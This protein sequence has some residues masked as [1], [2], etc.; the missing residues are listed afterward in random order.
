MA[1]SDQIE[2][3]EDEDPHQVDEVP[4]EPRELYSG[5]G[6]LSRA[7]AESQS[8]KHDDPD[9]HVSSVKSGDEEEKVAERGHVPG[10]ASEGHTFANEAPPFVRLHGKERDTAS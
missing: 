6:G 9:E 5:G 10:V 7:H 2:Q 4:V 1:T 8:R 3:C